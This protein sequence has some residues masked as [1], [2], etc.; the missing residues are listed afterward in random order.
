M[1]CDKTTIKITIAVHQI[2][3]DFERHIKVFI[4]LRHEYSQYIEP[5]VIR[6]SK[7]F[8]SKMYLIKQ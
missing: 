5:S 8:T 1:M 3:Y 6:T 2:R 7:Q 4:A